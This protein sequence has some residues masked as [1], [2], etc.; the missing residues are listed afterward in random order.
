MKRSAQLFRTRASVLTRWVAAAGRWTVLG[1]L[2]LWSGSAGAATVP[3]AINFQG[4]LV[5]QNGMAVTDGTYQVQFRICNAPTGGELCT[6]IQTVTTHDGIVNTM[7]GHQYGTW[8]PPGT[9][10]ADVFK[11]DMTDQR[12]L[13]V[14]VQLLPG[15]WFPMLP[16]KQ[17]LAAPYALKAGDVS[18]THGDLTVAGNLY[19]NGNLRANVNNTLALSGVAATQLVT[20]GGPVQDWQ[21]VWADQ[22]G[23][24]QQGNL[25]GWPAADPLRMSGQRMIMG[26]A[27]SYECSGGECANTAPGLGVFGTV[28]MMNKTIQN[29][30]GSINTM[31]RAPSDGFLMTYW[32]NPSYPAN[33]GNTVRIYDNNSNQLFIL[34][35]MNGASLTIPVPKNTYW[36]YQPGYALGAN[37]W[38]Q[39][40]PQGLSAGQ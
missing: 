1:A 35:A 15:Q 2:L 24:I 29:M 8:Q 5:D 7:M 30:S 40:L 6:N 26:G 23:Q 33:A 3:L 38:I 31:V 27:Y 17:L 12:F 19:V 10:L 21:G 22:G 25:Q 20:L 37:F 9:T 34:N 13:D 4:R 36:M 28:S 39:W 16:R 18:Q 11:G 32:S 14:S